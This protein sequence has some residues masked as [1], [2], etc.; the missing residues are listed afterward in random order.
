M[1]PSG[2]EP[3]TFRL[4]AQCLNQLRHGVPRQLSYKQENNVLSFYSFN[5]SNLHC[6]S[7]DYFWFLRCVRKFAKENIGVIISV[8]PSACPS[9]WK[10]HLALDRFSW[11][12]ISKNLSKI[13]F[14]LKSEQNGGTVHEGL[15]T[16][17]AIRGLYRKSW[18]TFFCMRTDNSRRRR[19]RWQMEPAVAL[20][21]S[22]F[23]RQ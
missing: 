8:Y 3:A 1:T 18:A 14:W 4:V 21:L 5:K 11:K 7:T 6:F 10:S 9:A 22:V 17:M 23:W 2:I 12:L 15:C 20:S 16:F 13:Y 19:V